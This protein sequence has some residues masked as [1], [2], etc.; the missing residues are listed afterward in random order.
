MIHVAYM[1]MPDGTGTSSVIRNSDRLILVGI[2]TQVVI[3][4]LL[5]VHNLCAQY[6]Q[7]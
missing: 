1:H 3:H 7:H 6:E 4:T 2:L 5:D